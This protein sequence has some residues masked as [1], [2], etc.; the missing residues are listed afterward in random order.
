MISE[1]LLSYPAL[2]QKAVREGEF[3]FAAVGLAHGHI[4]GICDGLLSAGATLDW[5]YEEDS[6]LLEPFKARFPWVRVARSYEEILEDRSLKMVASAAIPSERCSIGI[7]AME[8]GMDYLCDKAPFVTM[9]AL[10]AARDAVK[11]TG[12]KYAVFYSER[13]GSESGEY[14]G[15][16]IDR[17]V[18]GDVI[19]VIGL[20]PHKHHISPRAPWF[21]Q[22]KTSGGILIDI[23][24]HQFEQFLHYTKNKS[25]RIDSARIANYANREHPEFDDFGDCSL[26]G[27]N[28]A[29]G[30]FRT[31]WFTPNSFPAFGD[32]R[33]VILGTEG[34]IELRKYHDVSSSGSNTVLISNHE[35][36]ECRSVTGKI[37]FPF[38][39]KLIRDCL[40]RTENAMTQEHTFAA[41]ELA[42]RAQ[43][44][45][46][47]LT[48]RGEKGMLRRS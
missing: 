4:Y 5:V 27:E 48:P 11:R 40:D 14:A 46:V 19:N 38:F 25:A 32:G 34:Y 39:A 41:A 10:A 16:L 35:G 29:T 20:G 17:G 30:Y 12:K 36:T 28:G 47:D 21:Y 7:K 1:Q 6:A 45:A 33:T 8:S 15:L 26:T 18:I 37:G 13:L 22:R 9:E 2:P 23:G 24:S 42:V 3:R 43:L 31:D 44:C